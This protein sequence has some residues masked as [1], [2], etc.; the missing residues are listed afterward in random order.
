[1]N[2]WCK[3]LIASTLLATF[4]GGYIEGVY[5]ATPLGGIYLTNGFLSALQKSTK[6]II[7]SLQTELGKVWEMQ[8][9]LLQDDLNHFK[10]DIQSQISTISALRQNDK[11]T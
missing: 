6:K 10:E 9:D 1:M 11:A 4:S 7:N 5:A 2:K 8:L 3:A